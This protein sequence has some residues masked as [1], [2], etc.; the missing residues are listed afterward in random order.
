MIFNSRKKLLV[1]EDDINLGSV[2]VDYLE[3]EGF[4]V[5]LARNGVTGWQ[6]FQKSEFD[7][8]LLDCM[9]PLRD[10]FALAKQIREVNE[11]VPII[12]LTAKSLKEDKLKGFDLGGDDYITK[13]FDEE[14]LV[15]RIQAVLKRSTV[16]K[17]TEKVMFEIGKYKFDF[18]NLTLNLEGEL[19]RMTQKEGEVLRYFCEYRNKVVRRKEILEAIWGKDDYFHGRSLDVFITKLRKY[20]KGDPAVK[21]QNVHG[22]GFVLVEDIKKEE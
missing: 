2:L 22:V 3:M 13:P 1:V 8:C 21:I 17:T 7:M 4:D 9:L 11:Q 15:R 10:G 19:T 5:V 20:L 16:P 12:F 6:E 18:F 14:E